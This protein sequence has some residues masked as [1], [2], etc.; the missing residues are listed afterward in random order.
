MTR[1]APTSERT[2]KAPRRAT[3]R[4]GALSVLLAASLAL[5]PSTAA[6]ADGIRA[7]EWAL[8]A[9]HT[10]QAWR[11]TKGQGIT[12]AVLDTGVDDQHPDLA[13]NVLAGKDMVGFGAQRGDRAWARHGTAMAGII[14]GHGHGV[15]NGDGVL[16]IAPEA[17]ILP[18]R[19]I[20]EDGDSA[21]TR[22]RNTRGNALAEGIRWATDHGADVINLSLGD[23]SKSAHPEPAEDAAVQYAL[24]KGA[25]VVA[26]A[27]NGGEKG[28]HI[29]Y[30]AA[31]PGVIAATAVD[32]NGTHASFSTRRWYATVSAPGVDVVIADPDDRYYEGWG[33]SAASAFVSGAVALIKAAHPGLS[34]AQIKK[35]LEDT[36]RN[37][38]SGGRDDSR[39][40]GFIDPAAAIKAAGRLKPD[41]THAAAYGKKYFGKGPDAV[42]DDNQPSGW[43]GPAAGGAGV[44]LLAAS[45]ILWRGRRF[46]GRDVSGE[47]L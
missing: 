32:Q 45:V 28:D 40:F 38:P 3:Q 4:A 27:G 36:A 33:T 1:K 7:Q 46:S 15:G 14:A 47:T 20:L 44:L 25:V 30:P 16:G 24:K 21:R 12:V 42:K 13:G 29:S 26:S 6:H 19:V 17:K 9:M 31:Y 2:R 18:V 37:A 43:V 41:S 35:L 11:T 34:P 8:D 5:L 23:D 10:Q 22:A 39:G